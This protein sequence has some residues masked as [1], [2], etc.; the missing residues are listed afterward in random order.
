MRAKGVGEG[1]FDW[2]G[3]GEADDDAPGVG[4]AQ[5]LKCSDHPRLHLL[6]ALPAR[7][8]EG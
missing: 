1:G 7:E 6:E 8:T 2:I 4:A 3:M 5:G